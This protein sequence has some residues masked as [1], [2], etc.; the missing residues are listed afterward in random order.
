MSTE[1]T[2]KLTEEAKETLSREAADIARGC[3]KH[4]KLMA[5]SGSGE[6]STRVARA[7]A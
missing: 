7:A 3:S 4:P 2:E 6:H 1:P 5:G